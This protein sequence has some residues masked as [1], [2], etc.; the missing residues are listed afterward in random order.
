M[1]MKQRVLQE[2]ELIPDE[3]LEDVYDFLHALRVRSQ[4]QVVGQGEGFMSFAGCWQDM[5]DDVFEMF[6]QDVALRRKQAFGSRD[7]RE[8]LFD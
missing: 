4:T 3:S 1:M 2:I 6:L 7:Q 5:P 8:T